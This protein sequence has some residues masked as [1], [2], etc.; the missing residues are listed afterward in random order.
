MDALDRYS[1]ASLFVGDS[2]TPEQWADQNIPNLTPEKNLLLAILQ[3]VISLRL[4]LRDKT[5]QYSVRILREAEEWIVSDATRWGSFRHCATHLGFDVSYLRRG[6]Q[7][8]IS[9]ASKVKIATI[10]PYAGRHTQRVTKPAEHGR[11]G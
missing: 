7:R 6:F 5:D 10:R 3:D 1:V 8:Q 9:G 2:F 4:K 11:E